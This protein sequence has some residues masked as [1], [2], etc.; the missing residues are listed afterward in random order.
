MKEFPIRKYQPGDEYA[1][2]EV[3]RQTLLESNS[4]D[5]PPEFIQ[6]NVASHSAGVIA[7]R[8]NGTQ[9]M[10]VAVDGGAIVGCG[11]IDGYWGSKTES[12]L[13]TV[14][15]LPKYQK[16]GLGRKIVQTLEA[17][18]YFLRAW[19]TEVGSSVT[20]VDFYRRLG[21][22]YKNG[23]T[24]PDEFGVI[25][26]EKRKTDCPCHKK[27]CERHGNCEACRKHHRESKRKRPVACER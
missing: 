21:Y 8:A 2:A 7:E 16:K 11:A 26:L 24:A 4:Q 22:T 6:E 18:P 10:Y 23:R 15:V 12:Y 9:H 27:K 25:R 14:F 5:Y 20:A 17:D 3:V 19:R 13:M 1:I